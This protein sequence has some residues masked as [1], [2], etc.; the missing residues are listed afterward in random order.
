MSAILGGLVMAAILG[1]DGGN[2]TKASFF[3]MELDFRMAVPP[4]IEPKVAGPNGAVRLEGPLTYRSIGYF[5]IASV[6]PKGETVCASHS[7]M[8]TKATLYWIGQDCDHP[9]FKRRF[10]ELGKLVFPLVFPK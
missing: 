4:G 9:Y 2:P 5:Y 1:V 7:W 10:D 3:N 8:E 6:P